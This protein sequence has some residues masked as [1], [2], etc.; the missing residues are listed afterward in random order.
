VPAV[1]SRVSIWPAPSKAMATDSKPGSTYWR[2]ACFLGLVLAAIAIFHRA[3]FFVVESSISV[4][5]YSHI[6]LVVPVSAAF[7]YLTRRKVLANVAYSATAG[8]S[9]LLLVAA[10]AYSAGHSNALSPSTYLSLSILFFAGCCVTA[11]ALCYG[12]Q[13]FRV[14]AFPL[15]F[16]FLMVPLPDALLERVTTTLQNGSA[17]AT[18]VLFRAAN[19]PYVR[20]GVVVA[21]PR[22]DIYIAEECSGI[23][24]SMVLFLCTLVLGQLYLKSFWTKALLTLAVLPIMV[25]K[26]GLRIFVLST[27]GMY[28]D[29]SFLSGRL[30]NDGGFIFFGLAFAGLFLLI[31]LF[32]KLGLDPGTPARNQSFMP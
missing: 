16:L 32:Q 2:H 20:H 30:H 15:L 11:F 18:C 24:S 6:L 27:L 13:A 28:V 25:A 29:P 5:Q 21:L 4:D 31:W 3:L 1:A 10:F 22:I 17:F 23:R 14:A 7:L 9:F 8:V 19:I 26:N 12:A